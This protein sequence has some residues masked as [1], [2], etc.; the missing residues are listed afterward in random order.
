MVF[1]VGCPAEY[2]RVPFGFINDRRR[3]RE[4]IFDNHGSSQHS[5][6]F[7]AFS[8]F[9]LYLITINKRLRFI[10]NRETDKIFLDFFIYFFENS[11]LIIIRS[12]NKSYFSKYIK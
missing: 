3:F 6:F 1:H 4:Q 11:L 9:D 2:D 10:K 8:G 5:C 7:A 12:S